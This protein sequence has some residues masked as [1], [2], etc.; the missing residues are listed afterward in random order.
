MHPKAKGCKLSNKPVI[1]V[2]W[3]GNQ[4]QIIMAKNGSKNQNAPTKKRLQIVQEHEKLENHG[5]NTAKSERTL[6]RSKYITA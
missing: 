4:N 6:G 2:Y 3:N 5:K 1:M